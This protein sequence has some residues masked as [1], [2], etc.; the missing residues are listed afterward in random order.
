MVTLG[1]VLPPPHAHFCIVRNGLENVSLKSQKCP[2]SQG[3]LDRQLIQ[4]SLAHLSLH[5]QTELLHHHVQN[6]S[7]N[8][9]Q[10]HKYFTLV[11]G[12]YKNKDNKS[13]HSHVAVSYTHLTL[14]TNREV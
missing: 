3:G 5:I 13:A 2:V 12:K 11:A 14:P 4:G 8:E 9:T 6:F 7:V 1:H 10:H